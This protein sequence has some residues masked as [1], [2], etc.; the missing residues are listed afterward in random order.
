MKV[1]VV[2]LVCVLAEVEGWEVVLGSGRGILFMPVFPEISHSS[3]GKLDRS[4]NCF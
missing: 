3:D 4:Q 1:V 2:G